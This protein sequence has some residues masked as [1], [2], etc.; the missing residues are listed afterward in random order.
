MEVGAH[1]LAALLSL[2]GLI[3]GTAEYAHVVRR[4][5]A[6]RPASVIDR[7]TMEAS[8]LPALVRVFIAN[9]G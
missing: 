2:S 5:V 4:R 7:R 8:G 3:A 6:A 1:S 9:E